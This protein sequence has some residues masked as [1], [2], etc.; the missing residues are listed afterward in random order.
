MV[1]E[2]KT[3]MAQ[4]DALVVRID[5]VQKAGMEFHVSS[6]MQSSMLREI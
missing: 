5:E 6:P 1:S 3:L 4:A 2:S